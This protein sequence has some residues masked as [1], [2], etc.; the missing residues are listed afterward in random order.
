MVLETSYY[1]TSEVLS[2]LLG[3]R[4]GHHQNRRERRLSLPILDNMAAVWGFLALQIN[5]IYVHCRKICETG[6]KAKNGSPLCLF[7]KLVHFI[8][9]NNVRILSIYLVYSEHTVIC[10]TKCQMK[11]VRGKHYVSSHVT[12]GMMNPM[13]A[14]DHG[15]ELPSCQNQNQ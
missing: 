1:N 12:N 2:F 4:R 8:F 3:L 6:Q 14:V 11:V 13:R 5:T 9:Y 15:F 7:L 10:G